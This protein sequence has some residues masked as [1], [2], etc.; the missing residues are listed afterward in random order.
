MNNNNN[1]KET[2]L[3]SPFLFDNIDIWLFDFDD[4]L[5]DTKTYFVTS[6]Q[7]EDILARL[8][9]ELDN[10]IPSWRYFRQLI[11]ELTL[12]GKRVGIVSFGT[13]NII[14]A[15][16]D[17][18][19]GLDQKYFGIDNIKAVCRDFD[20]RPLDRPKN[21]NKFIDLIMKNYRLSNYNRVVLFDD[22]MSNI[23]DAYS[24][25]IISYKIHGLREMGS[26]F[27]PKTIEDKRKKLFNE[28][29]LAILE[30][31]LRINNKKK[32]KYAQSNVYGSIGTR[33]DGGRCINRGGTII[34]SFFNSDKGCGCGSDVGKYKLL[35][36]IVYIIMFIGAGII[37]FR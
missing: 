8:N 17:R 22:L 18:I 15:Y 31:E 7:R 19:F 20:G 3:V 34:E 35:L 13:Y 11:K 27:G 26:S 1:Y 37:I 14:K 28:E 23:A 2:K 32:D 25:G 16:M 10:E 24:I 30:Y 21:K 29:C 5:I 4:T 9:I 12:R 36:I 6:M 33:G